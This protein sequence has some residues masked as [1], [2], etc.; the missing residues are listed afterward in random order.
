MTATQSAYLKALNP[1]VSV[2]VANLDN[3]LP[4]IAILEK[5]HQVLSFEYMTFLDKKVGVIFIGKRL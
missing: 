4:H 3:G 5:L 1:K 2:K